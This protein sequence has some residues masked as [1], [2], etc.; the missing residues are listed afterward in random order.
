MKL[1]RGLEKIGE[2]ENIPVI[3]DW[4]YLMKEIGWRKEEE[5]FQRSLGKFILVSVLFLFLIIT[6]LTINDGYIIWIELFPVDNFLK[7]II[8][9]GIFML[10]YVAYLLRDRNIFL[11]RIKKTRLTSLRSAINDKKPIKN[12]NITNFYDND[13]LNIVD[14]VLGE[15]HSNFLPQLL[16]ELSRYDLI[17]K[18]LQRLGLTPKQF[19]EIIK[20]LSLESNID[21][22]SMIVPLLF[23]TFKI[24]YD[25]NFLYVD[26][27]ALFIFLS[28][29]TLRKILLEYGVQDKEVKA[30]E[31]WVKNESDKL[32]YAKMFA[33]KSTLKP[34]STVNRAYTTKYSPTLI[35]YS[36]DYTAEVIAGDFTFSIAREKELEELIDQLQETQSSAVLMLGNP[37][38]GKTTLLK[39]LAVRMVVEDVP[40]S[41]QDM[42]LVA[43]DFNRAFALASNIDDFKTT[44]EKSLQEV[45]EAGNI[46]LVIDN[47]DDLV[48][49]RKELSAEVVNLV[50]KAHDHFKIKIVATA[51]FEGYT[52]YIKSFKSLVA[53]FD[54]INVAEPTPEVAVQ[55]LMDELPKLE[56][57]FGI[58]ANFETLEKIVNL[59]Y[60]FDFE[61]VL[62]D[63]GIDLLEEAMI[64]A[65]SIKLKFVSEDLVDQIVSK[66]VGV[67]IGKL[68]ASESDLFIKLEDELHKK[69]IGQHEAVKAVASALRRARAGLNSGKRPL[70]SFLFTG[71]TGVG[72]TELA[73]TVTETYY[74][75]TK[76]MIRVDMS[77]YQEE[78]NLKRLIGYVENGELYG[79][80]LTEAVRT[81]PFAL[82]LLDEIEKANPKVLDIFLQI[83]DEGHVTDGAGRKIDFSNTIIIATSNVA[84]KQI[85]DLISQGSDY[86]QVYESVMP[87][88]REYLRV[89]F[90]NRFDRVIMFK[91]LL[92]AEIEQIAHILLQQSREKLLDKGIELTYSRQLVQEVAQLGYNPMYGARELRRVVQDQV[93]DKI[94]EM[95]LTQKVSTGGTIYLNSIK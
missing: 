62:P 82:I 52:R 4:D 81:R 88:I 34:K 54:T 90:L 35:Q 86:N 55:I 53:L 33:E 24:A 30:V 27:L 78:D 69:V 56:K 89:E 44:L 66:K 23:G 12:I 37:G 29:T 65:E 41:L 28:R 31:L 74:G 3:V 75:N 25:N 63:K 77:E 91:P 72:K 9:F 47:I 21:V 67:N 57:K 64:K 19:E 51:T 20:R 6:V 61:R 32:R 48:N 40:K 15:F 50:T 8:W 18:S 10:L 42:R 73:K 13:L 38:V 17:I 1:R 87:T 5:L 2:L 84:S 46:I 58:T 85:A 70:A 79:G 83:L 68:E 14:D 22:D 7:L 76:L 94:A 92:R 49:I 39:S 93:E 43:F 59:S 16:N 11:D 36:R 45:Y 60:K 95:I 26:E 80:Y 71:P